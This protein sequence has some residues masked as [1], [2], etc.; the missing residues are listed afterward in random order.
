MRLPLCLPMP[1]GPL[2]GRRGGL[3]GTQ[4]ANQMMDPARKDCDFDGDREEVVTW[5]L[6]HALNVRM[7]GHSGQMRGS[8]RGCREVCV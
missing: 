6:G 7:R 3:T 5:G 4:S 8:V 1:A 2:G